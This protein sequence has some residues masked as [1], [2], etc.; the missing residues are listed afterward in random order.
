MIGRRTILYIVASVLMTHFAVWV[1]AL[2]SDG[3]SSADDAKVRWTCLI[4][5]KT[6][7]N[8]AIGPQDRDSKPA[9]SLSLSCKIEMT[10]PR[11]LLATVPG[12]VIERITDARGH[13]LKAGLGDFQSAGMYRQ[14]SFLIHWLKFNQQID[15]T[16]GAGGRTMRSPPR[17]ALDPRLRE[18]AKGGIKL[19]KGHYT[20]L[21]AESIEYVDV[22]FRADDEW[23]RITP[24]LEIRVLEARNVASMHH[25][26]IEQRPM[27]R[28][29]PSD[30]SVGDSF[31]NRLVL[32]EQVVVRNNSGV[33]GFGGGLSSGGTDDSENR[34]GTSAGSGIGRAEKIRYVIAVNPAHKKIPFE[35]KDIPLSALAD[36]SKNGRATSQAESSIK[37]NRGKYFDVRWTSIIHTQRLYNP[38]MSKRGLDQTLKLHCDAEVLDPEIVLGTCETP[39][40]EKV[41]DGKG[42]PVDIRPER[43]R[44]RRMYYKT[45]EYRKSGPATPP[46]TLAQM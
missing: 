21:M 33:S 46:S 29:F 24:E 12:V 16:R 35:L 7:Q 37:K 41:T 4:Y 6:L 9:E 19:I 8:R 32:A 3:T 2:G 26:K 14:D 36:P 20:G 10:D 18:Q 40:I 45:P 39:I 11:L 25:Y 27:I 42:R 28:P 5:E 22:P 34:I 23:I 38:A 17:L 44:S 43:P 31:P 1:H 13:E 15:G 30:Y